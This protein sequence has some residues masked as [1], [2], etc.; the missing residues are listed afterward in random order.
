MVINAAKARFPNVIEAKYCTH[1]AIK[2]PSL[3]EYAYVNRKHFHLINVLI[4]CDVHMK[5]LNIV[6]GWPGSTHD[7]F[8]LTNSIVG[9]RLQAGLV[10]DGWHLGE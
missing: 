5:L 2:A 1:I 4:I 9:N 10:C 3:D 8:I 7:S 6:A